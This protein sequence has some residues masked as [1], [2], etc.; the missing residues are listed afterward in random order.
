MAEPNADRLEAAREAL[1]KAAAHGTF[2][3]KQAR[4]KTEQVLELADDIGELRLRGA[5]WEQVAEVLKPTLGAGADTIRLAIGT[6]SGAKAKVHTKTKPRRRTS[7][8]PQAKPAAKPRTDRSA[9]ESKPSAQQN[10]QARTFG[11]RDEDL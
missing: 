9:A 1:R 2:D 6:V 3:R 4:T 5:T 7:A 10:A 8:K 11:V